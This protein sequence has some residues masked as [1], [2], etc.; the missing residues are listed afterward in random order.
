MDSMNRNHTVKTFL[1]G[2]QVTFEAY[3]HF[4]DST[5]LRREKF[6]MLLTNIAGE[7]EAIANSSSNSLK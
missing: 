3:S 5:T 7:I 2:H 4:L 1:N 6:E